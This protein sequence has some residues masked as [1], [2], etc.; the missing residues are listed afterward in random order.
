MP[1]LRGIGREAEDAAAEY[2]LSK[3]YTIVTRRY[4]TRHG[5]IDIIALDQEIL[6]FI[7]VKHRRARD[8]VPEEGVS[9]KKVQ[10]LQRAARHYIQ[11]MGSSRETRYDLIAIDSKGLRHHQNT[12]IYDEMSE[13]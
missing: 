7:E 8:Y 6:V 5:E 12:F 4:C 11:E 9:P 3:G 13:E 2:L 10:A 1:N